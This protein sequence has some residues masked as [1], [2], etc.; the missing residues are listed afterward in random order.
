MG[1]RGPKPRK[2]ISTEWSANL[3][4]CVGLIASDGSL[5]KDGR[6]IA[7]ISKDIEQIDNFKKCLGITL[8]PRLDFS[9]HSKDGVYKLQFGSVLFYQFLVSIGLT[10]AKTK[11]IATLDIPDEFFFDF[12]RGDLDGD[13]WFYSYWDPRW[14]SSHMFY[15]NFT[16]ASGDHMKWMREKI[17]ELTGLKG[18]YSISGKT[19]MHTIKYAKKEALELIKKMYYSPDVVSLSRKRLKIEKALEVE[20]EQQSKY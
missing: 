18:H 11:T 10:F 4:Y 13:G 9:G 2:Y 7:L 19:P 12:L 5:S 8:E 3:A 6:H 1:K 15:L 20:R 14:R 16:S 17:Y